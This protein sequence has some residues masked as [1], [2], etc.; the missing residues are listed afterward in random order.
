M[1][2]IR[3]LSVT[4]RENSL[5]CNDLI[6]DQ[7]GLPI[8]MALATPRVVERQLPRSLQASESRI[9]CD[10]AVEIGVYAKGELGR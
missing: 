6:Q 4:G 1:I 8:R 7:V 5:Q 2:P 10:I 3:N 9:L